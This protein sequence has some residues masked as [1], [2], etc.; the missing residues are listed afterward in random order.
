ME[1]RPYVSFQEVKDRVP[2]PEALEKLGLPASRI[3]H[4]RQKDD[5]ALLAQLVQELQSGR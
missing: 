3:E 1:T 5:P 4:L 2:I